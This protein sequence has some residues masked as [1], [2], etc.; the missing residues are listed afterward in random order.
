MKT[1]VMAFSRVL[2]TIALCFSKKVTPSATISWNFWKWDKD[3]PH[4]KYA[5]DYYFSS[6][7]HFLRIYSPLGKTTSR[8]L[9]G[10]SPKD[11]LWTSPYGPLCNAKG[12]PLPTSWGQPLPTSLGRWNMTYWGR[13][14][15]T[16]WGRAHTL[17]H[18]MPW[19]FPYRRFEGV[20]CRRNKDVPI[21]FN[22]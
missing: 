15:V 18:V 1:S 13:P 2:W 22:A 7:L 16:S 9:L 5:M 6:S 12:R 4:K 8:G 10:T 21:Q 20:S 11:V 3:K 19:D 14:D 17:L